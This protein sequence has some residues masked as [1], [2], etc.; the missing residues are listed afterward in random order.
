MTGFVRRAT[1]FTAVGLLAASA[2]MAGVPSAAQSTIPSKVTVVGVNTSGTANSLY[3]TTFTI[4]DGGGTPVPFSVVILSFN[5]CHTANTAR[6]RNAQ[7]AAGVSLNCAAKTVSTTANGSGVATFPAVAG[8]WLHTDPNG[9][10][11]ACVSVTADGTPMGNIYITGF[12]HNASGVIDGSDSGLFS[13]D[14]FGAFRHR[15]DYNS[16]NLMDGGDSGLFTNQRFGSFGGSGGG[17][18]GPYCL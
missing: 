8:A 15:S 2:A 16:N 9:P 5:A 1:L 6:L 13:N 10:E 3:P 11:T 18:T 7:P 4:R 14:R 17:N 12:D